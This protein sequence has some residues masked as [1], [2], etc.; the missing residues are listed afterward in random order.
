[1]AYGQP[2]FDVRVV[3]QA[4]NSF[5]FTAYNTIAGLGLNTFGFLWPCD[6]IW[7]PTDEAVVTVWS[8][9]PLAFVPNVEDCVE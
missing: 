7:N 1:M 8:E 2:P 5:G 4:L 3:G 6:S 9:C